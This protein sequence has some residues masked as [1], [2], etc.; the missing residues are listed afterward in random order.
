MSYYPSHT[1]LRCLE[2]S[3]RLLSFTRAARELHL[4]QGAVSQHISKLE[5]Q[6]GVALFERHAG[7][8]SLTEAG[9]WFA[10]QVGPAMRQIETATDDL[11]SGGRRQEVV[12]LSVQPTFADY[13]LMPRLNRFSLDHPETRVDIVIK[14]VDQDDRTPVDA[15]FE[16]CTGAAPGTEALE[17]LSLVYKPFVSPERLAALGY[18]LPA[19]GVTQNE[20]VD[21]LHRSPLLKTAA[22]QLWEKWLR[23]KQL[24]GR[25]A[26]DHLGDGPRYAM[27]SLAMQAVI[28]GVGIALLPDYLSRAPVGRGLLVCLD[29]EGWQSDKSYYMLWQQGRARSG[30]LGALIDWM[31]AEPSREK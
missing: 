11:R 26:H 17:I 31:A 18:P 29:D 15:W 1:A 13:W 27:A 3:A 30:G 5:S 7:G 12:R 4:T 8:L 14:S 28:D 10:R 25:I 9:T 20:M 23:H 16:Q 21:I 19:E 24:I 2:T 6:L 22:S